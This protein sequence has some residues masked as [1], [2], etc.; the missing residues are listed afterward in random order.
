M[1]TGGGGTGVG[2]GEG[3]GGGEGLGA[4]AGD[5]PGAGLGEGDGEGL[6]V[7]EGGGGGVPKTRL[8]TNEDSTSLKR[9]ATKFG[10]LLS[11]ISIRP[12]LLLCS[13]NSSLIP[14]AS[15][16]DDTRSFHPVGMA[17][18]WLGATQKLL[19]T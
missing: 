4:G 16:T 1:V 17:L 15:R 7:G 10:A 9:N 2:A 18:A 12:R 5:G 13:Y 11:S 8:A 6:G 14:L 19:P 3:G